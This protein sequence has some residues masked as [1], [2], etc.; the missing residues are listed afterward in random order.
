MYIDG[1]DRTYEI[2]SYNFVGEKCSVTYKNNGKSY[3][4]NE[5][6]IQI[7]KSAIQ[8]KNAENIFSYLKDIAE[9]VGLTTEEGSNIIKLL[10]TKIKT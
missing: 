6:R 9:T 4:Y 1:K 2:E 7:V 5:S 3:S 8:T 10:I